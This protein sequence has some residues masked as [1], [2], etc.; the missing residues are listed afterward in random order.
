[1][2]PDREIGSEFHWDPLALVGEDRGGLP[3]WVPARRE[4]FATGC[5]AIR[6]VL[7]VLA[8]AGRLHVPSYFCTGVAEALTEC[9]PVTFYRHLPDG[10]GPHWETLRVRGGDVVLA[11][12]LFGWD[13]KAPWDAWIR[14][15][16]GIAVVEDHSHD[17]FSGWARN[18]I[19]AYVVASL[20]KTL[21]LPDGGLVWSPAGRPLPAPAG[22]ESP[23]AA[24]KLAAMLLKA[25]WL[26][27]QPVPKEAFRALQ[28][29][30]EGALLGS[31]GP[32]ST[33][34]RAVLPL[35]DVLGIRAAS[36]RNAHAL[37]TALHGR[38]ADEILGFA[39]GA[40]DVAPFRVQLALRSEKDRDTL[41]ALLA[42][43]RIYAPV[44]WRQ[45]RARWWS[46]DP[47]AAGLADRMLTLP[48]DH[49]CSSDD[50]SRMA[51]VVTSQ[52]SRESRSG[53]IIRA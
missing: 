44:H 12:N 17:P 25:G 33:V 7:R 24:Q 23:G 49:R 45:D 50:V 19:A 16:P 32:A 21:P 28:R 13:D 26:D 5:G 52:A 29:Q 38:S 9:L 2:P 40:A 53:H 41:L 6:A 22:A 43:E 39:R 4:L 1:M 51:E 20:R 15:H 30:G 27:G 14:A 42:A 8:P 10:H 31:D 34:T 47:E 37:R 46:G 35:L 3:G 18:S 11:Q 48:V 36:S